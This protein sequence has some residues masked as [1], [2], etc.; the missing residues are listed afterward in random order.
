[1]QT[2]WLTVNSKKETVEQHLFSG[3]Q[4]NGERHELV[5]KEVV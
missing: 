5:Q 4:F 3:I 2:V 1:M